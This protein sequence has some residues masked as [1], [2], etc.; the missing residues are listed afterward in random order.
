MID[1][2]VSNADIVRDS[3]SMSKVVRS[4]FPEIDVVCGIPRGGVLP[5]N[6]IVTRLARPC[7][8]PDLLERGECWWTS[9]TFVDNN[10][11]YYGNDF[12]V[13]MNF[14]KAKILLVDDTSFNPLGTLERVKQRLL[15]KFP[16]ATIY[17]SSVY[18]MS[19]TKKHLDFY[20]KVISRNHWFEKD[21]LIR[22]ITGTVAAD[23]DGFLCRDPRPEE[24]LDDN[25]YL[26]FINEATP[27]MI[28]YYRLDYVVTGRLERYRAITEMWLAAH[29]VK[30]GT[31]IMQPPEVAMVRE[32]TDHALFKS[33]FLSKN[34]VGFYIESSQRQ[35]EAIYKRSRVQTMCV[36]P[37]QLFGATNIGY[38][39][40]PS[41][42]GY[43]NL[44]H[45]VESNV[46]L[47][48]INKPNAHPNYL[49]P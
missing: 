21:F 20:C 2:F 37:M 36:D 6:I 12:T 25:L 1:I 24:V 5:A 49:F 4:L 9:S 43:K 11:H 14:S 31:L 46:E 40:H 15:T 44:E 27:Y 3:T 48:N 18:A 33:N 29:G 32:G 8:T 41:F 38:E 17:K 34:N 23:M 45:P 42:Q 28:P 47:G 35:S 10:R 16:K 22:K 7:N 13:K 30:Y 19:N 39:Y 26:K